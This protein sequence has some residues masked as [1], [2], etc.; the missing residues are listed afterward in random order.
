MSM[1]EKFKENKKVMEIKMEQAHKLIDEA[2][3]E[4]I[5]TIRS[6]VK[7]ASVEDVK[8]FLESEDDNID[9][10]DKF[11]VVAAYAEENEDLGVT[12]IGF[13]K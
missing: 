6:L 9:E 12:I 1:V 2:S 7:D 11:A 8:M 5:E 10:M 3:D 13:K 4:F